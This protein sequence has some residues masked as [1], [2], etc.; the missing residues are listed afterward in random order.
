M[1]SSRSC[2]FR[3]FVAIGLGAA[4]LP[5]RAVLLAPGDFGVALPGTTMAAEP[6][7]AG[8]VLVDELIPFA[9]SAGAGLDD[10]SGTVQQRV[11]RSAVDGTLDFYWRVTNADDSAAAIGSFRLGNFAA[12]EYNANWRSDGLG[13][14]AP[15]H[16]D[17]F[18]GSG[19]AYVNF[20]F[21]VFSRD[22]ADGLLPGHS[23]Y[24]MFLDTTARHYAR[25]A[26]YDLTNMVQNPISSLYAAYAPWTVPVPAALWLFGS[27]LLGLAA[28]ARKRRV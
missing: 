12:P 4:M 11:V 20:D 26:V 1:G 14:T 18:P 8:T 22:P 19:A 28:V 27:G 25:S 15:S 9:F 24:F 5:A 21:D 16:A 7:L 3:L 23:S 17:R 2:R 10:I 6:Q 13:D